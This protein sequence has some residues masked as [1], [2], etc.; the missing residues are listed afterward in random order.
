M[1]ERVLA[2]ELKYEKLKRPRNRKRIGEIIK[3]LKR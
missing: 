3:E 1:R 2:L